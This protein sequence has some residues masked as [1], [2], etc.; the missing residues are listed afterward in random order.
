MSRTKKDMPFR[1]TGVWTHKYHVSPRGHAKFAKMC[2]RI[3][4]RRQK[5]D[6]KRCGEPMPD[7]PQAHEY[8][9]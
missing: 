2:R 4:R 5:L 9:D 3:V 6:L 8:F 1:V 7:Y